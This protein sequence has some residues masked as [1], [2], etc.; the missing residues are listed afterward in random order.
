MSSLSVG[1]SVPFINSLNRLS[2]I[3]PSV[4]PPKVLLVNDDCFQ[5]QFMQCIVQNSFQNNV[6]VNLARNGHEA[7]QQV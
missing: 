7:L 1:E 5:M 4:D 6:K 3:T 2:G